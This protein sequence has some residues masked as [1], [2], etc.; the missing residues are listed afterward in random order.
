M[1]FEDDNDLGL[2]CKEE[3]YAAASAGQP[4]EG[5]PYENPDE[6]EEWDHGW[7]DAK[8]DVAR[9]IV[10]TIEHARFL[11]LESIPIQA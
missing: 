10:P 11:P 1:T 3:G 7:L 8:F 5:S 4:R 6:R 2:T 9:V